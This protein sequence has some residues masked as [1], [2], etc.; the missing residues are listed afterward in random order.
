MVRQLESEF[1]DVLREACPGWTK[2][3]AVAA[4]KKLAKVGVVDV[5]TLDLFLER[6]ANKRLSDAG[7]KTFRADTLCALRSWLSAYHIQSRA[8]SVVAKESDEQEVYEALEEGEVS[9]STTTTLSTEQPEL[10]ISHMSAPDLPCHEHAAWLQGAVND[11]TFSLEDRRWLEYLQRYGFC[12]LHDVLPAP[13]FQCIQECFWQEI[14]H[15]VPGLKR[16]S[17][18]TWNFPGAGG[19]SNGIIRGYG[20]PQS[21][22]AWAVRTHPR[23]RR[24]FA[25]IFGTDSLA[26]SMDSVKLVGCSAG[27]ADPPW[28][29]RDQLLDVPAY[30]IQSIFSFYEVGPEN[31]GTILI[32]SSHL[33][34]YPWDYF[35]E[36]NGSMLRAGGR[37]RNSVRIPAGLQ[38]RFMARAIKP[39]VPGNGL[40]L[41]NSRTIHA[42]APDMSTRWLR[43]PGPPHPNRVSVSV[44]MCPKSRRSEETRR[45]KVS[46]LE[47]SCSATHWADDE[48]LN[49]PVWGPET[50][51]PPDTRLRHLP[52]PELRSEYLMML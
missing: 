11:Y 9:Q 29:H 36:A 28:L 10:P 49:G 34:D 25:S 5:A 45:Y 17:P 3:N 38:D 35:Q 2:S 15:V 21:G 51:V 43:E 12:V 50:G 37:A 46:I 39:L 24:A 7:L 52:P 27:P 41:F 22:F 42:S 14:A 40:I 20:L 47:N 19:S 6:G 1:R 13:D 18:D 48:L 30:S 32:P 16:G 44:A 4:E 31:D 8:H 26:V 23:I 33:E